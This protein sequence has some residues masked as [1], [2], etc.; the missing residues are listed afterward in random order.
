[1]GDRVPMV[2]LGEQTDESG[3]IWQ[4]GVPSVYRTAFL[5]G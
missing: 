2:L 3:R 4:V 1:M 5:E